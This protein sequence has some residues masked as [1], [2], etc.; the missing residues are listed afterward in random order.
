MPD[1]NSKPMLDL[2]QKEIETFYK[3]IDKSGECWIWTAYKDRQGYGQ[4]MVRRSVKSY[5]LKAHRI[6]YALATGGVPEGRLCLLHK[7]DNPSCC[8]PD[9]MFEGTRADN[10]AD[11]DA[12]GRGKYSPKPQGAA[13]PF[14]KFSL[15]QAKHIHSRILSGERPKHIAKELGVHWSTIYKLP[16]IYGLS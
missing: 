2:T 7:C 1:P 15:E 12:K 10:A 5:A 16:R 3:Y 8:R 9:H 13:S 4:F 11:R 6:S 14:A